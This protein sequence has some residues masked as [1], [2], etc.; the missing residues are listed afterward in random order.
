MKHHLTQE[1]LD[2]AEGIKFGAQ[3]TRAWSRGAIVWGANNALIVIATGQIV[4]LIMYFDFILI[5]LTLAYFFC[6]L[7]SPILNTFEFRPMVV[8][9]GKYVCVNTE[10]DPDY[11]GDRR[12]KSQYRRAVSESWSSAVPATRI[13]RHL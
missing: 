9:G 4:A 6:F 13:I 2:A 8:P 7:V 3:G 11:P 12:Y 10:P 5:P 1:Q